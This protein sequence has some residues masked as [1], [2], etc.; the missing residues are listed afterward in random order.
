MGNLHSSHAVQEFYVQWRRRVEGPLSLEEIERRLENGQL[1]MISQI[2]VD[3]TWVSIRQFFQEC[4]ATRQIVQDE[5]APSRSSNSPQTPAPSNEDVVSAVESLQ[6]PPVQRTLVVISIALL[7]IV[8]VTGTIFATYRLFT[9]ARIDVTEGN[10]ANPASV[11]SGA[12]TTNAPTSGSNQI[13][14]VSTGTNNGTPRSISSQ[15]LL[16]NAAASELTQIKCYRGVE[17]DEGWPRN[18][19]SVKA[20][21]IRVRVGAWV[22]C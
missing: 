17:L 6:T 9:K 1:G 18:F 15:A 5:A 3:D 12:L 13:A 10:S 19:F 4:E 11:S 20:A 14:Q 22:P 16:T 7:C 8:V 21:N 2:K